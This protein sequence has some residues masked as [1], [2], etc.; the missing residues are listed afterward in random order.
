MGD[1][2]PGRRRSRIAMTGTVTA[3]VHRFG[4]RTSL[5]TLT[6]AHRLHRQH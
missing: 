3:R 2:G 5:F 6:S 4:R 1:I